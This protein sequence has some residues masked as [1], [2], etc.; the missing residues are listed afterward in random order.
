[1]QTSQSKSKTEYISLTA[2]DWRDAGPEIERLGHRIDAVRSTLAQMT[3]KKEQWA[4]GYWTGVEKTLV[5]RWKTAI[6]LHNSGFRSW[7]VDRDANPE[8]DYGWFEHS[9]ENTIHVPLYDNLV[10]YLSDKWSNGFSYGNLDRAWA[11]AQEEKL[12]KARQG[13]A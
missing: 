8:I 11:M 4:I 9:T 12:Q 7:G 3:K 10:N 2:K 6:N 13:L 1:V 5:R